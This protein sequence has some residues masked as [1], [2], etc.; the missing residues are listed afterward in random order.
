MPDDR[1]RG[2]RFSEIEQ[3]LRDQRHRPTPLDL[4]RI[5]LQAKRQAERR[6]ARTRGAVSAPGRRLVT[7]A[8]ALGLVASGGGAAAA[9]SGKIHVFTHHKTASAAWFQYK[10]PCKPGHKGRYVKVSKGTRAAWK[11]DPC[12]P[13]KPPPCSPKG[14]DSRAHAAG[15]TKGCPPPKPPPCGKQSRAHAAGVSHG[16]QPPPDPCSQSSKA[17]A[18]GVSQG[19]QPTPCS[20]AVRGHAAGANP[21]QTDGGNT[22]TTDQRVVPPAAVPLI[23][24]GPTTQTHT[25][26]KSK[27]HKAK[28][29]KHKAKHKAKHKKHKAKHKKH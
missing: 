10:P 29:K 14:K 24:S 18:A 1:D 17:H 9:M 6:S 12:K 28:H 23:G 2:D 4:D 3:M 25:V 8:V 15:M 5:K 22:P 11:H 20:A 13:H 27:K 26:K 19:C 7:V 16:C 21:C